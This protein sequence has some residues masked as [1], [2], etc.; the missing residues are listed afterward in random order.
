MRFPIRPSPEI[1]AAERQS[2]HECAQHGAGCKYGASENQR[3][4]AH[5]D[6]FINQSA[7]AGY[8]KDEP[9]NGSY[10]TQRYL[11]YFI[12]SPGYNIGAQFGAFQFGIGNRPALGLIIT[13]QLWRWEYENPPLG[14]ALHEHSHMTLPCL[15]PDI[16]H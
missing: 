6:D 1:E 12:I 9:H 15:V 3:Q 7:G 4:L 8:K 2:R 11:P 13:H 5:P 14:G 10:A 16:S